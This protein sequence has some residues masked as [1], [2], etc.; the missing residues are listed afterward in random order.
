MRSA[1]REW[2]MRRNATEWV[3]PR[4]ATRDDGRRLP[5]VL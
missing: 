4:N 1:D 2:V 3:M 5:F